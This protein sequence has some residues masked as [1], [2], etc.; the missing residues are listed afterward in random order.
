MIIVRP[1]IA[2]LEAVGMDKSGT[3][4]HT[5]GGGYQ[6]VT[7]FTTRS[8]WGSPTGD[9]LVATASG[10]V[11]INA[12]VNLNGFVVKGI[13][14]KQNGTAIY[15][16]PTPTTSSPVTCTVHANA[17]AGDVFTMESYCNISTQVIQTTDTYMTMKE[18]VFALTTTHSDNFN[19]A[20][21]DIDAT[22]PWDD[23]NAIAMLLVSSNQVIGSD[24]WN[25]RAIYETNPSGSRAQQFYKVDI[26]SIYGHATNPAGV[27]LV[28]NSNTTSSSAWAVLKNSTTL[29]LGRTTTTTS[30]NQGT[31]DATITVSTVTPPKEMLVLVTSDTTADIFIDRVYA[32]T[33]D[34]T[35]NL[36][37]TC[38]GLYASAP[39]DILDNY[40]QGTWTA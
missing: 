18:Q 31:V 25:A 5:V 11:I 21:Q 30:S 7:G 26:V 29:V 40:S 16:S 27:G 20:N 9:T 1:S 8:G 6:Q 22:S 19:R 39:T 32:G 14:I 24:D 34:F 36:Y 23:V 15:T 33:H 37:G 28:Y 35:G 17:V 4:N 2:S 13:R 38:G 12:S 3:Q 10:V